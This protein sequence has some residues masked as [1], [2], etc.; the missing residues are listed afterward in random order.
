MERCAALANVTDVAGETTRTFL[1]PA[2]G[3]ANDLVADWMRQAGM[4]VRVDAAGNLRGRRGEAARTLVMASHLDTVP[5]AGAYDGILGVVM[6]IEVAE[7][8][9]NASLP[10]SLEVIGFSEEEGVRFGVPFIGS[11]A[12]VGTCDE[13]LLTVKDAEGV[14]VRESITAYGLS[15]DGLQ[16]AI[17]QDAFAYLEF[18]IEQGPVLE[19]ERRALG[20][21]EAVVGQSRYALTFTGK[22]NH[23]G[24][25][26]M[27]LRQ[28][29]MS[30][31]A[32]WIVGVEALAQRTSGLV[33]TVGSVQ[34]T[35][36]AGN[37]IAGKVKATLDIRSADDAV[38]REAVTLLLA[39]AQECG[40]SRGV[41][42]ETKLRMDQPAVAMDASLTASLAAAVGDDAR[43]MVSGAGHD[44]MMVAPHIP[45]AMLFLRSPGGLS[46][47]PDESVLP[48][49]VQAGLEAG[50]RFVELLAM[51]ENDA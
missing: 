10:F 33:A 35:P 31:A 25:T 45:S 11:R 39:R 13:M 5:N 26:P 18:H 51:K 20:V 40:L 3:Q 21:V 32:E 2:M 27:D 30:A 47:H 6:A 28:D 48:D 34:T 15:C 46:H 23:A 12:L 49:D 42:V 29:A 37:V 24:T 9:R 1:S 50:I 7:A 17:L 8:M 4:S 38:R 14:S 41:R 36:G 22:A 43:R 19:A 44:A 16:D